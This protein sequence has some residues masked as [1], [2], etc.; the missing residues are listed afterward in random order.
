[1]VATFGLLLI[2]LQCPKHRPSSVAAV[3]AGY[4]TAT[5]WF[6]ASTSFA[7]P[8]VTLVR[9]LT[10]TFVGIRPIDTPGFIAAQSLGAI[11]AYGLYRWLQVGL[12]KQANKN[13]KP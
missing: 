4:I 5:Y 12:P 3:V 11:L 8:A 9:S 6:T 13:I 7:N 1:M 10:D 2:I